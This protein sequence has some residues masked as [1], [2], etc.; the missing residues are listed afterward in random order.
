MAKHD[1][2]DELV[3]GCL[4]SRA[5]RL[6]RVVTAIYEDELR[7]FDI[8][9]SQLNLLVAVA[10]AGPVRRIDIGRAT[11]IDPSTLTRNLSVM[12]ANGWI[13]E[14]VEG[15]DGRGN[16]ICITPN[17]RSLIQRV[18]PSWRKAQQRTRKLLGDYRAGVLLGMFDASSGMN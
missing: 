14:G 3:D 11:D 5:R 18:G 10:K 2:I 1:L 13:K 8:K 17:G 6:A 7:D 15:D 9:P 12:L 4:M 16:P